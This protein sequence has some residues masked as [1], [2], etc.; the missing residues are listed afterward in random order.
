MPPKLNPKISSTI[1]NEYLDVLLKVADQTNDWKMFNLFWTPVSKSPI[2]L[3]I[4]P[5]LM[6]KAEEISPQFAFDLLMH[7]SSD[8][9]FPVA[10]EM[11]P[12]EY[13]HLKNR[14]TKC[15]MGGLNSFLM[16]LMHYTHIDPDCRDRSSKHWNVMYDALSQLGPHIEYI[17]LLPQVAQ[18]LPKRIPSHAYADFYAILVLRNGNFQSAH[19]TFLTQKLLFHGSDAEKSLVLNADKLIA[20]KR[21]QVNPIF[22]LK[23][24]KYIL[25][26]LGRHSTEENKD[27]ITWIV[28]NVLTKYVSSTENLDTVLNLLLRRAADTGDVK[29]SAFIYEYI[30]QKANVE[31]SIT[32][33]ANLFRGFRILSPTLGDQQCFDVLS[34]IHQKG[35]SIPPFLC[36]EILEVIGNRYHGLTVLDFY[37]AYFGDEYLAELGITPYCETLYVTNLEAPHYTPCIHPNNTPASDHHPFNTVALSILYNSVLNTMTSVSQVLDLYKAFREADLPC[38]RKELFSC[39]DRFISTL[40]L[41]FKTHESRS[42]AKSILD[43]MIE[44]GRMVHP[45]ASFKTPYKYTGNQLTCFGDLIQ[46]FCWAGNIDIALEVLRTGLNF[47]TVADSTM[48]APIINFYASRHDYDTALAWMDSAI[49]AGVQIKDEDLVETLEN[50]RASLEPPER[51]K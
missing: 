50:Y 19:M 1:P 49:K 21:E 35:L 17:S 27:K 10:S 48:F 12:S 5:K 40:C 46:S 45:K 13:H 22:S 42:L 37:K 29:G 6:V 24:Y 23:T 43:D 33:Y 39:Y 31:P 30:L 26:H 4:V 20:T 41:K 25:N 15:I 18:T 44:T 2:A 38:A 32:S 7:I 36:T 8:T 3:D 34:L 51:T 9:F 11:K 47:E 16:A 28:D 14:Y